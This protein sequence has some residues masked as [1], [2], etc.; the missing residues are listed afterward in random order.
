VLNIS[1]DGIWIRLAVDNLPGGWGWVP[2]RYTSVKGD[3][4]GIAISNNS[5]DESDRDERELSSNRR[6]PLPG[7]AVVDTNGSRLRVRSGPSGDTDIID[8]VYDGDAHRVLERSSNGRWIRLALD[9]QPEGGWVSISYVKLGSGAPSPGQV[10]GPTVQPTSTAIVLATNTSTV[11]VGPTLTW[12]A[13]PYTPE[14]VIG[15]AIV[16]TTGGSRLRVREEPNTSALIL[17]Y[18]YSDR[19]YNV[20]QKSTDGSWVQISVPDLTAPGWVSVDFL[21]ISFR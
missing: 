4:T 21:D 14:A 7:D 5:E 9:D 16:R 20:L 19:S 3:I 11:E 1:E 15:V 10:A 8:H 18:A 6:T 2:A 12:T 13:V 17:G